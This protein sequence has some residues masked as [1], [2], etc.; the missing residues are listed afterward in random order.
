MVSDKI[1]PCQSDAHDGDKSFDSVNLGHV[2]VLYVE[3]GGFHGLEKG[4]D[5]PPLLVSD[6]STFGT[7]VADE[8]LKLGFSGGV[9]EPG[10]CKIHIFSL[11]KVKFMVEKLLAESDPVEEMPCADSLS[12]TGIHNSE[13]LTDPDVIPYSHGIEP[14]C[15]FLSDKLTV[16]H[17]AINAAV[18]EESDEPLH[19]GFPFL[20]AGIA[21]FVQKF[22]KQRECNAFIGDTEHK[23][24][25]V[26]L[27]KFPIGA[28]HRENY[29]LT[30]RQETENHLCH[31]VKAEG[32]FGE[33]PLEPAHIGVTLNRRGHGGCQLM[34]ADSLN[35]AESMDDQCHQLYAGKIHGFSKMTLHNRQ[36]LVN[37]D[38]ILGI[39]NFH[40][41]KR[42][43]LSLKLV[44]FKNLCKC[45]HLKIRCL[46]E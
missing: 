2:C 4:L 19:K 46:I 10:A 44:N 42:L 34:Q 25:N 39:G 26:G 12:G 8:N 9:P 7:V 28:V 6:Y 15:P 11:H 14:S 21:T 32:I 1:R 30:D 33:E 45:N 17:K 20:P 36:D 24:V 3:A 37:F 31:E 35:H 16:S 5:L 18:T 40:G 13:V 23:N 41:K 27:A 43:N 29:I 22:E 38:Q